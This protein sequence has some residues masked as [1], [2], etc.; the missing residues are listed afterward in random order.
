VVVTP[1]GVTER[2]DVSFELAVRWLQDW[3]GQRVVFSGGYDR[4]APSIIAE[5]KLSLMGDLELNDPSTGR[6]H[7]LFFRVGGFRGGA[8]FCLSRARFEGASIIDIG[9]GKEVVV[10]EG[11]LFFNISPAQAS[12]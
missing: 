3:S 11:P 7:S 12:G 2:R 4:N 8:V 1:Q 5:G 10:S 9:H 6:P